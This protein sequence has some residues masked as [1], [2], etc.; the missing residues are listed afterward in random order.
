M[1]IIK[2]FNFFSLS[3]VM[4]GLEFI[5]LYLMEIVLRVRWANCFLITSACVSKTKRKVKVKKRRIER[6]SRGLGCS[7]IRLFLQSC[8]FIQ[9]CSC[10]LWTRIQILTATKTKL[11]TAEVWKGFSP[12]KIHSL[13]IKMRKMSSFSFSVWLYLLLLFMGLMH[14]CH[15][16]V[17]DLY[18]IMHERN[19]M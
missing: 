8:L 19:C 1:A 10:W 12:I 2:G 4:T 16:Y 5:R 17:S 13:L 11:L 18:C 9:S 7:I 14:N 3:L 15:S 6:E